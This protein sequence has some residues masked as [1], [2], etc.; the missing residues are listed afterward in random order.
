MAGDRLLLL[1]TEFYLE[2]PKP[3][4]R[5]HEC[6]NFLRDEDGS[7]RLKTIKRSNSF[8]QKKVGGQ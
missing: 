1:D 5:E 8:F 6:L 2:R 7:I 3:S 4:E